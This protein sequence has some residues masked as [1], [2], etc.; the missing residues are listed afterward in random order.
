M[1]RLL[2]LQD[3]VSVRSCGGLILRLLGLWMVLSPWVTSGQTL[4]ISNEVQTHATLSNTAVTLSGKSEL[5]I[6][7]TG[8]PIGGCT[9]NLTSPDSWFLLTNIQPSTVVSTFLSRVKVNGATAVVDSNCRVVQYAQGTVVIPQAPGF[10]PMTVYSGNGFTGSSLS[11]TQYTAYGATELGALNDNISSFKLKRG[12]TATIA[13]NPAGTGVSKNYVAQDGDLEISVLPGNLNNS[14]SFVRIFP[15]RWVSKKGSCDVDPVALNADWFYNW[16]INSNSTRDWEYVAI[17]QQ[18]NWPSTAQDWKARGVNHLSGF[19]EPD[20]PVEDAYQNLTPQG[21]VSNAVA[22]WDELL[23]TGLRV[24]APAVTDGG[25]S[26]I[27]DFINQANAAGKRV[28]YVPVHYY[29]SYNNNNDPSGA[30]TQLY[31]FLKS[32]YDATGKPIWVTE[33]NNGADWTD[34][35]YDPNATQNRNVVEAMVNMMDATPWIE[36]YAIYSNVEWFRD[37]HYTDGSLTPM[38]VMYRDHVA[39]M[40]YQQDLPDGF[41]PYATYS[42]NGDAQDTTGYANDAMQIGGPTFTNAPSPVLN[43]NGTSAYLRLPQ[44]LGDSTD[45]TFGGWVKWDGGGD[46]QRIFDFGEDTGNYMFLTPKGG[47]NLRFAIKDGGGEQQ[48][49]AP[50]LTVGQWTHVAVTISGNTGKLFVNGVLADTN[51]TMT[52]NPVDLGT[53]RNYI[54][55]SQFNDPYFK[56]QLDELR[57]YDFSITEAQVAAMTGVGAP[58]FSTNPVLTQTTPTLQPFTG[59]LAGTTTGGTGAITF[60]KISG[61]AWLTVAANG[62]LT[63]VPG[64]ADTGVNTFAVKVTDASGVDTPFNTTNLQ[65]TVADSPGMTARY[66][67]EGAVTATVGV[68]HGVATGT[69]AY[70]TG[71]NASAIDLDGADDH[72][73]L[74]AGIAHHPEIT[75]ATWFWRDSTAGWQRLF[76][77][78]SGTNQYLFLSPRSGSATIHFGIKNGGAEQSLSTPSLPTGQW[79]HVAVTLGANVGK[80]YVNGSLV[81]TATITLKPT[82]FPHTLNYLGKSQFADPLFDGRIDEFLI[83]NQALDASQ[84]AALATVGN[85]APVFSA[86]PI[87]MPLAPL[88]QAYNQYLTSYASDP[89]AGSTLTFSKVSGPA[90][91][92]VSPN[93]RISGVPSGAD[94]GTNRFIVRVTDSTLLADDATVNLVVGNPAGLIAHHQFDG[95]VTDNVGGTSGITTTGSPAYTAGLFDNAIRFDGTDDVVQLRSGLLNGV[96]DLTISA[97]VRWNGGSD[98][99][100]I[101]DFGNGTS[102]Y[103]FF[104]PKTGTTSRFTIRNGAVE[105]DLDGPVL[106][107]GEWSHIAITLIGNTGTLY[108][109]GAPVSTGSVTLD[110]AAFAPTVNYLGDSQYAADPLFNGVIDDFRIYNVG[111]SSTAVSALAVPVAATAVPEPAYTA[112]STGYSFPVGQSGANADPDM[113]GVQNAVEFLAGTDPLTPSGNPLP[114]PKAMSASQL[115]LGAEAKTYLTLS[116]R[117]RRDREGVALSPR[118]ATSIEGLLDPLSSGNVLQA[119]SPVQDGAFETITYYY[120]TAIEDSPQGKGF[121][122]FMVTVN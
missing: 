6:T 111:L 113:D 85:R 30:A 27:V 37:T 70:A 10:A 60:S 101:F 12:Y 1:F 66:A 53:K 94:A 29:R 17:K 122:R 63:G 41:Y 8:D 20:N 96:T 14:V 86:D 52:I 11:L 24:G 22:R 25:Y 114:S 35:A 73:T 7:G 28:D 78:G 39:P 74:P 112:W 107:I 116:V 15:W 49:N 31:N 40:A 56:G 43:L 2:A 5:R 98:W 121:M 69:P 119:G 47:S 59:S 21:S 105:A 72:V 57:F 108:L 93:G 118:A 100:R 64:L 23:G 58:Q 51:T 62:A 32:I 44:R 45:F 33:F 87:G 42:F 81:D 103:L 97:R 19:N 82:D 84:I 50:A 3:R 67:F 54:G 120:K 89:N 18:P 55:K 71:V 65:I 16:N 95:T 91:L 115:G 9:I 68:G 48:L 110:P 106:P 79:V 38:G 46:W 4:N 99:Q 109:N 90:W 13:Q 75:I 88:D 83:F 77:F 102:Q 26:W 61:P 117:V 76:D 34:N 104:T 92:T 80:L 36:R